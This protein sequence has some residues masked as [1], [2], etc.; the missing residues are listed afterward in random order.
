[1][2][3][4]LELLGLGPQVELLGVL[5]GQLGPAEGV[6]DLRKLGRAGVEHA[7]PDEQVG[8]ALGGDLGQRHGLHP[9]PATLP[10]DG[11]VNY[12]PAEATSEGDG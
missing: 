5:D 8:S 10:V 11:A 9:S 12:H 7:Q 6:P 3:A 2:H 1:M 4:V